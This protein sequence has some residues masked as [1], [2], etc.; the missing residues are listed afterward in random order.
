MRDAMRARRGLIVSGVSGASGAAERG[1]ERAAALIE[2]WIAGHPERA[3]QTALL[4][5]SLPGEPDTLPLDALLRRHRAAVAYPRVDGAA[6]RL[7][8]ATPDQ[9][10]T[11]RFGIREPAADADEI[12]PTSVDFVLV[13]GL[14][15]DSKGHRLG[16][17]RGFYDALLEAAPGAL[18]V[19]VCLP[20]Q[21]ISHVPIEPHD[22]CMD[23]VLA[24]E[25][26]VTF[27]RTWPSPPSQKEVAT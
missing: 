24:D 22:R 16:F 21:L 1:G 11:G 18:R 26:H 23:L 7:H 17:G 19:G 5:A 14:A 9:L 8:R 27:A 13:P 25:L 3:P 6:L 10:Q 2:H 15:F 4:F 20:E 12:A